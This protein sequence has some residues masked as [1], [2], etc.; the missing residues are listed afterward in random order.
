MSARPWMLGV[1]SAAFACLGAACSAEPSAHEVGD[2]DDDGIGVVR[3]AL[4]G[5]CTADPTKSL[6][7]VTGYSN[8]WG[9]TVNPN[10]F[11]LANLTAMGP[12]CGFGA[13][14][15]DDC[16]EDNA[17]TASYTACKNLQQQNAIAFIQAFEPRAPLIPPFGPNI[18]VFQGYYYNNGS[19]HAAAVDVGKASI[20]PG[21]DPG[22]PVYAAGDG[23]V[24]FADW[25][26]STQGNIVVL[27]HRLYDGSWYLTEYR[28]VRGGAARDKQKFCPC[29]NPS[30]SSAAMRLLGCS[31]EE[32]DTKQCKYAANP[33]YDYYWGTNAD[34]LPAL[35]TR[36]S[37]GDPLVMAGNSGTV[38]N[39]IADDGTL[40]SS[41]GNIHLHFSL[42]VPTGGSEGTG[43]AD[44]VT[45]DVFGVYSRANGTK[46]GK[47][48]Y[49]SDA[50]TTFPRLVKS[51]DP[52]DYVALRNYPGMLCRPTFSGA[53]TYNWRGAAENQ[54]AQSAVVVC[55]AGRYAPNGEPFSDWVFGRVWVDDQSSIGDV[56]CNVITKNPSGGLRQGPEV[57][58]IGT[59]AQSLV[60]D[61]PKVYDPFTWS[62]FDIQ[63]RLPAVYG[64][65]AS[66][67]HTYRV[68]Q[69][70]L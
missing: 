23:E 7:T 11:D 2:D 68:Q 10:G 55:P 17:G 57:C 33:A 63:C 53:L 30:Q 39:V 25:T 15:D 3:S 51:F 20:A 8:R 5:I 47:A 52:D 54:T 27:R 13:N 65:N 6:A 34:E 69:Q 18:K 58:T 26:G 50:S 42:G 62:H 9:S 24:V 59:G 32:R 70:R 40:T 43:A 36:F 64:G 4:D 61:Y 37:V 14:R 49:A 44:V 46:D 16:C 35:G 56:C 31:A 67:I 41:H 45:L 19:P 12:T 21:E 22:F 60:L 29:I 38:T 48:C 1:L 28:H 66:S